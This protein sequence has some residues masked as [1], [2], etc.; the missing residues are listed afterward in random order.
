[1]STQHGFLNKARKHT[2]HTITHQHVFLVLATYTTHFNKTGTSAARHYEKAEMHCLQG[3]KEKTS[4]NPRRHLANDIRGLPQGLI[5]KEAY[6]V[7]LIF[8]IR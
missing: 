5:L 3:A 6:A 7:K 4:N 1:M 2:S 8:S